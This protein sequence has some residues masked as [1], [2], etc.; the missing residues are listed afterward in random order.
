MPARKPSRLAAQAAAVLLALVLNGTGAGAISGGSE[1]DGTNPIAASIAYVLHEANYVDD[2]GATQVERRGCSGVLIAPA[3]VLTTA[4]CNQPG[5]GLGKWSNDRIAIT[6][7]PKIYAAIDEIPAAEAYHAIERQRPHHY[8]GKSL[9]DNY[10]IALL[11]L[12]REPEG[13]A[14]LPML[15]AD[16]PDVQL[17]KAKDSVTIVGFGSTAL[18]AEDFALREGKSQIARVSS[19]FYPNVMKLLQEPSGICDR[20]SGGPAILHTANGPYVVGVLTVSYK[21]QIGSY[22]VQTF[23]PTTTSW[24]KF[25]LEP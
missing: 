2:A 16:N 1:L 5:L 15:F 19:A 8:T 23:A 22:L 25:A 10:D 20:D 17:V 9:I 11:W 6:F 3:V 13:A 21:C 7:G 4:H 14:P 12:D 24:L 18:G